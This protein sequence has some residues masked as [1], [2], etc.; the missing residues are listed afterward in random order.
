MISKQLIKIGS[1]I[2]FSSWSNNDLDPLKNTCKQKVIKIHYL[3]ARVAFTL[4][5]ILKLI[6]WQHKLPKQQYFDL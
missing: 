6:C 1:K 5:A 4:V 2:L 3:P